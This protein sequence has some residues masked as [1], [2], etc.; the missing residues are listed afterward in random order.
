MVWVGVSQNR[1]IDPVD[2]LVPEKGRQY[3]FPD[4]KG[5]I[6]KAAPVHKHPLSAG[7]ADQNAT[8]L[9]DIHSSQAEDSL[10]QSP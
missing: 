8:P 9:T 3:I 7:K 1:D 5:V 2:P 4:V 6:K 10:L